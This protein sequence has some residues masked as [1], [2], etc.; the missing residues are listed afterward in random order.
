MVQQF[1]INLNREEGFL[2]REARKARIRARITNVIATALLLLVAFFTYENDRE[3]RDIIRSKDKQIRRIVAQ[4]DSL[5]KAGQNVSKDDVLALAR[6]DRERVLWTKKIR[7]MADRLPKKM[8]LT[9]L[10]LERG[11]LEIDAMSEITEKEK[12]FDK[13]KLF[14]DRL[15]ATPLFF[16]DI[17]SMKFKESRR[18]KKEDQNLLMFTV[19]CDVRASETTRSRRGGSRV[20]NL[21]SR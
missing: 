18:I 21:S 15:R 8:V 3:F 16:E 12:E 20:S 5:Q 4:I 13:V 17:S 1:R 10:Q 6:L 2:Q 11:V 19:R 9:G 7:A 14:M